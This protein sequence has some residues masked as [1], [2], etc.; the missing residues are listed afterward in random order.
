MILTSNARNNLG[1]MNTGVSP[2]ILVLNSVPRRLMGDNLV[3]DS[4]TRLNGDEDF[5]KLRARRAKAEMAWIQRKAQPM[6]IHQFHPGELV[7]IR[8]KVVQGR[9]QGKE[10]ALWLGPG[11]ILAFESDERTSSEQARSGLVIYVSYSGRTW[12]C[13]PEQLKALY[14]TAAAIRKS[15]GEK[16]ELKEF[17][18]DRTK[19]SWVGHKR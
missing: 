14:P 15:W 19:A 17:L 7:L 6:R 18:R 16:A 12:G 9:G 8:R 1:G 11:R 2:S 10:T 13:A 5:A 3:E 4:E